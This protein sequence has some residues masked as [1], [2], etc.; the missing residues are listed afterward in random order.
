MLGS[1]V[2]ASSEAAPLLPTCTERALPAC[3]ESLGSNCPER[4]VFP[5]PTEK[6]CF[7]SN[8]FSSPEIS[9]PSIPIVP[10]HL[11]ARPPPTSIAIF[12]AVGAGS[13][14]PSC[15]AMHTSLPEPTPID[16]FAPR[17]RGFICWH[18]GTHI[19][20]ASMDDLNPTQTPATFGL[21]AQAGR[22]LE[23]QLMSSTLKLTQRTEDNELGWMTSGPSAFR[24]YGESAGSQHVA[25]QGLQQGSRG[26]EARGAKTLAPL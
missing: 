21:C 20:T 26:T 16:Q 6:P 9:P 8:G 25:R 23:G 18:C 4:C 14:R 15:P 19:P 24:I 13:L 1:R 5:T 22:P 10:K 7:A 17:R 2:A 3:Q 12:R 11:P